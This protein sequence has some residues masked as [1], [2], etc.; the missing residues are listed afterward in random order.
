[1]ADAVPPIKPRRTHP[2]TTPEHESN[3]DFVSNNLDACLWFLENYDLIK[4]IFEGQGTG[5]WT[6]AELEKMCDDHM[7]EKRKAYN[8][9]EQLL[10]NV[11]NLSEQKTALRTEL[12]RAFDTFDCFDLD[13]DRWWA[14]AVFDRTEDENLDLRAEQARMR[15]VLESTK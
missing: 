9:I 6:A 5:E 3:A 15:A 8:F 10:K 7:E 11:E 13:A 14:T 1:M 12:E 4:R 2:T